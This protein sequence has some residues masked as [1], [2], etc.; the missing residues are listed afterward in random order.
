MITEINEIIKVGAIFKNGNIK[1]KWIIWNGRKYMIKK[2]T[3]KWKTKKGDKHI[4]N[5]AITDGASIFEVSFIPED[6]IW[7]LE[8]IHIL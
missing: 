5:F 1:I 4:Y 3:Y 6:L 8:K 7:N 2:I